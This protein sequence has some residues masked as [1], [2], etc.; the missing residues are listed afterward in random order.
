MSELVLARSLLGASAFVAICASARRPRHRP[1]AIALCVALAISLVRTEV[2]EVRRAIGR[3][4]GQLLGRTSL[5][6][7]LVSPA[8]SAWAARRALRL[9]V[10]SSE[11]WIATVWAAGSYAALLV[12]LPVGWRSE[13]AWWPFV[14]SAMMQAWAIG[15][16]YG[17]GRGSDLTVLCL[18]V[19]LGGDAATIVS[20]LAW[21]GPWA[22]ARMSSAIVSIVLVVL[23][24]AVLFS[25]GLRESAPDDRRRV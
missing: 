15:S 11:L 16:W 17:A 21:S 9:R 4:D 2:A 18:L 3:G 23:H 10:D 20:P 19:L 5:A 25:D 22:L 13:M 12:P 24:L 8:A 7:L 14:A 1:V 6:I